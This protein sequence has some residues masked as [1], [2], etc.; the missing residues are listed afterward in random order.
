MFSAFIIIVFLAIS[1]TI[2][3]L[4][5]V[6]ISSHSVSCQNVFIPA[7]V[8]EAQANSTLSDLEKKCFCSNN[9]LSSLNDN[10]IKTYCG[11]LLND[12]YTEQGIQ[13]AITATSAIVNVIFGVIVHK[14]VSLTQPY[15]HS[16]GYLWKT[17]IYTI[18]LIINTVF[19]PLL[20]YANIFGF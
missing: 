3:G 6:Y 10:N 17:T 19:L 1:C 18:F 4:C 7:T 15:S 8:T 13:Y 16:V 2:I 20:I 9:F 11:S 5:S 12:I 14:L